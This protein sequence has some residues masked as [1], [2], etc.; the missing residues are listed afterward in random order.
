M[1]KRKAE[2][3]AEWTPSIENDGLPQAPAEAPLL[4][5]PTAGLTGATVPV[6]THEAPNPSEVSQGLQVP[7]DTSCQLG[8][9]RWT[10]Q[11][12]R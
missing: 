1:G 10:G 8:Q 6:L 2:Q 11:L 7:T 5:E 3:R 4:D 12:V 9:Q